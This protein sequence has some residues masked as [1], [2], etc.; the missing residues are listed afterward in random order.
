VNLTENSKVSIT[1]VITLLGGAFWL[2]S[3]YV[4]GQSNASEIAEVKADVKALSDMKADVAVIKADVK[5][6]LKEE[7]N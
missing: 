7:G 2:T 5:R 1:L 4:Q 6:L 3:V